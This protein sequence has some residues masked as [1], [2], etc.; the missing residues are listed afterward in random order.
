MGKH[1]TQIL[2]DN[3]FKTFRKI[4]K[5][6]QWEYVECKF[7]N[8]FSSMVSGGL[9]YRFIKDEIEIAYG[10]HEAHKPPTL[11][12]PRPKIK[13]V[14]NDDVFGFKT[15]NE[16]SDDAMNLCM[17]KE[18]HQLILKAMFDKN[19]LFEYDLTA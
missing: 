12:Y 11:I 5:N 1:I 6:K 4:L 9:D 13:M 17:Q 10:L 3:G 7:K 2:L 18:D 8:D 19:I 15:L 16:Q 14:I